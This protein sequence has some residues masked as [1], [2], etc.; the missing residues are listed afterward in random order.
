MNGLAGAND[1]VNQVL[2]L[3]NGKVFIAGNF[4]NVNGVARSRIALLNS[5]GSLDTGFNPD[6]ENGGIIDGSIRAIG[7]DSVGD[8][9]I[10]GDFQNVGQAPNGGARLRIARLDGT[11][12]QLDP[13]FMNV[14][15]EGANAFID[16]L[17][18]D[19]RIIVSGAFTAF[20]GQAFSRVVRLK[21][22]STG[23]GATQHDEIDPTINFG[24]GADAD[25]K[26]IGVELDGRIVLGG[27][28]TNFNGVAR[29]RLVRVDGGSNSTM[30]RSSSVRRP[31]PSMK[32]CR[33]SRPLSRFTGP[34][35]STV[36]C[37]SN[38]PHCPERLPRRPIQ[39]TLPGFPRRRP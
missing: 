5:D 1:A 22:R 33:V 35:D 30:A 32:A 6:T 39:R 9:L 2:P 36:L 20:S 27:G 14:G 21:G 18:D 12:G 3:S 31:M 15:S 8:V 11:T 37:R 10:A 28:F 16:N 4:T 13:D 29:N 7:V 38:I 23:T 17:Q 34:V 25:V 26:A 24:T 19:Q